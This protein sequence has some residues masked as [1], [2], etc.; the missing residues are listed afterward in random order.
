MERTPDFGYPPPHSLR[1]S[2]EHIMDTAVELIADESAG[3]HTSLDELIEQFGFTRP[4]IEA[5]ED[6]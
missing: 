2:M 1:A 3:T 5:I 6:D 4:E